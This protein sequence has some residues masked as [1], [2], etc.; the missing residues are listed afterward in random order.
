LGCS[1]T[2]EPGKCDHLFDT[3]SPGRTHL[4]SEGY[5]TTQTITTEISTLSKFS[6]G[7]CS[8]VSRISASYSGTKILRVFAQSLQMNARIIT[9]ISQTLIPSRSS[10]IHYSLIIALSDATQSEVWTVPLHES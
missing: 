2:A 9:Q 10:P 1:L 3:P 5:Y 6:S 7:C 4:S 8:W